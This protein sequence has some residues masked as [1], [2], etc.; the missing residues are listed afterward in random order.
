MSMVTLSGCYMLAL[1]PSSVLPQPM[2][3]RTLPSYS[4]FWLSARTAGGKLL[5]FCGA[6]TSQGRRM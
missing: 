3:V 1:V 2:T 4:S 5:S 6:S